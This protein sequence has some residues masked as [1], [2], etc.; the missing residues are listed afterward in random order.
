MSKADYHIHTLF[1]DGKSEPEEY[2]RAAIENNLTEMGFSDHLTPSGEQ[3]SWSIIPD[4]LPLY[5]DTIERLARKYR[6]QITLLAGIEVDYLPG[7]ID[8]TISYLEKYPFD[9]VIGS[10]H[11]MGSDPVDLGR[12]FY[13]GKDIA[14]L[15]TDYFRLVEEAASTGLFDIMAHPD[16]VRV[17]GHKYPG[18]ATPLYRKL[19]ATLK[20]YDV[21][22]EINT[23]G[24]NKPLAGFYPDPGYLP[25]FAEE[26]VSLCIN[27]DAHTPERVAQHFD[28]AYKLAAEAGFR[29]VA[30][31]RERERRPRP[32]E[33]Q[34]T[35][36]K[37]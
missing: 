19:A 15:F 8:E 4:R 23:N 29:E 14:K 26:G 30:H 25:L 12:S 27:S 10:V 36:T 9:Y 35:A 11:F 22:F 7:H 6:D 13:E 2:I 18:D 21:A 20:R 31:F 33:E 32:I 17:F 5:F 34:A 24:M 37:R 3:Q 28:E 1:S 16:L